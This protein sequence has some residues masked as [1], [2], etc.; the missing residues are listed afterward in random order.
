MAGGGGRGDSDGE[1]LPEKKALRSKKT[2][3]PGKAPGS[4]G[5]AGTPGSRKGTAVPVE[6]PTCHKTFLSKYYLKVH[7]R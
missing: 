2:P 4:A 6:C 7:N 1:I 3:P 5:A